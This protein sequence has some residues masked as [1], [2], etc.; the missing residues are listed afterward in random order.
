MCGVT[1]ATA[2]LHLGMT[3]ATPVLFARHEYDLCETSAVIPSVFPERRS[4]S[5]EVDQYWRTACRWRAR[6]QN[7]GEGGCPDG[8]TAHHR[9]HLGAKKLYSDRSQQ[10]KS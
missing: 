9:R 8:A 3:A 1:E 4:A 7:F 5:Q 6:T 2:Y 10:T